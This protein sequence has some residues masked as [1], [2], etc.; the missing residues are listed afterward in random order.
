MSSVF[1]RFSLV[2]SSL[3]CAT[4][5]ASAADFTFNGI[6]YKLLEGT[7]CHGNQ[8]VS[9]VGIDENGALGFKWTENVN[10]IFLNKFFSNNEISYCVVNIDDKL[11]MYFKEKYNVEFWLYNNL[12]DGDKK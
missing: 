4:L 3:L 2:T 5:T 8:L 1:K 11:R 12:K 9:V 6:T 7:D 10:R